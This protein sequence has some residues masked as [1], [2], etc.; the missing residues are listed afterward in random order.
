MRDVS[1]GC[2]YTVLKVVKYTA[3][4]I[5]TILRWDIDLEL[6]ETMTWTLKDV[7]VQLVE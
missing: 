1:L 3:W 4:E 2:V 7:P 5:L 6:G